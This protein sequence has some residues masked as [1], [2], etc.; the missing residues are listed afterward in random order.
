MRSLKFGT[1]FQAWHSSVR[2]YSQ[3]VFMAQRHAS[4]QRPH[5][6]GNGRSLLMTFKGRRAWL[7]FVVC[8]VLQAVSLVFWK[9]HQ[10][11]FNAL[12]SG[13]GLLLA[14]TI[15]SRRLPAQNWL[16]ALI[17]IALSGG[18]LEWM[19]ESASEKVDI[20]CR[21]VL[22]TASVVSARGTSA[23]LL[24]TWREN[25]WYGLWLIGV[26]GLM[27][28]ALMWGWMFVAL[29]VRSQ[30]ALSWSGFATR[31]VYASGC[32]FAATSLLI[33]KRPVS[34]T[35]REELS[36]WER[37]PAGMDRQ[38]VGCWLALCALVT[39]AVILRLW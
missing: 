29:D 30:G 27:S 39:E 3:G 33:S 21:A 14:G 26:A 25:A 6:A 1:G 2:S 24:K 4:I 37:K 12:L 23:W 32:L 5:S 19:L 16:A 15:L 13:S 20:V 31:V 17:I 38:A 9:D 35:A 10:A 22:W 28:G 36:G 11:L 7:F 34:G 18:C 8:S